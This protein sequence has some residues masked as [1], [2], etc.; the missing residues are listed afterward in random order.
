MSAMIAITARTTI[1]IPAMIQPVED[2][3]LTGLVFGDCVGDAV[4]EV[5]AGSGVSVCV[6][7][8]SGDVLGLGVG[9]AEDDVGVGE[10]AEDV[11]VGDGKS[12]T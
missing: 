4:P 7:S 2:V 10:V 9:K 5:I 8:G 3:L 11:G 6:G 1:A 12:I